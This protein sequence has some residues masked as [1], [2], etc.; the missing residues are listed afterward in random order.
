METSVLDGFFFGFFFLRRY[1]I[2]TRLNEPCSTLGLAE[3]AG[4]CQSYRSCSV[5]EDTGLSLAYTVAH[6]LGHKSVLFFIH[7]FFAIPRYY[8][9]CFPVTVSC[10][11][12]RL[13]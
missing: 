12:V 3:V 11:L 10:R 5:N 8:F 2:C 9:G 4:M 1:N 6:E 7:F 13:G